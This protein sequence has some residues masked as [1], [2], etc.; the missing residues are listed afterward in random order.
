LSR[1]TGQ[2]TISINLEGHGREEIFDDVDLSRT[3]GWFT[4]IFPVALNV[5]D[6]GKPNWRNLIKS[7]RRQL[8][9][10]PAN[11]FGFGALR[12][13]GT[14]AVQ[15]KLHSNGRKPWISFNYLGQWDAR[16]QDERQTLYWAVHPSIGQEYDPA[17]G[18]E[19]LLEV[20]GE[21][22]NGQLEFS[23]RYH[24]CLRY[25]VQSAVNDFVDA[26]RSIAQDCREA[27]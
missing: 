13:L 19:H 26:L 25:S 1:W 6:S 12:Y 27:V 16:S 18:D 5:E 23:W 15:E 9:T 17:N 2:R 4:S 21:V 11:G 14:Q 7:T 22:G 3:V 20:A 24:S 8:R 10:I